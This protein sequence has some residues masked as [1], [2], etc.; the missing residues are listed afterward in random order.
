MCARARRD[1]RGI[2]LVKPGTVVQ[3]PLSPGSR[4]LQEA[5]DEFGS[6]T[7]ELR[8]NYLVLLAA[9]CPPSG[10]VE[11][12]LFRHIRELESRRG[13]ITEV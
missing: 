5:L 11:Q 12:V 9:G 13:H 3:P 2:Q 4:Q 6:T 7:T 1:R 10:I 8:K